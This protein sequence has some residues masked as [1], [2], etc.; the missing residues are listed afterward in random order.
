MSCSSWDE[1]GAKIA[2]IIIVHR[3]NYVTFTDRSMWHNIAKSCLFRL[4]IWQKAKSFL[5]RLFIWQKKT[6]SI[7]RQAGRQ[8]GRPVRIQKPTLMETDS[9]IQYNMNSKLSVS[10]REICFEEQT[11]K[12]FVK[13]DKEDKSGH[14]YSGVCFRNWAEGWG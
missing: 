5:F 12:N 14:A 13:W 8:A 1:E 11:V 10:L 3:H 9:I 6:L 4:F 2:I 7:G